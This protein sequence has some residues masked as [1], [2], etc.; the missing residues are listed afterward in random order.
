M[1]I[2]SLHLKLTHQLRN[3][4]RPG[5]ASTALSAVDCALWDLKGKILNLPLMKLWGACRDG[6]EAYGSGGFTN[7]TLFQLE[8]QLSA[9]AG[10]GLKK[11]KMKVGRNPDEDVERVGRARQAVGKEVELFVDANGAYQRKQALAMAERFSDFGVC[12]F[13]EP[14]SSDDLEGLRLLR[15]RGPAGMNIAAGE[16]GY[17]LWYFRHMLEGG[18]V[19]VLQAD[20]SRCQGFT[21]F[22]KIAALCESRGM[23]ISSH[24]APALHAHIDCAVPNLAHAE[25]FYDHVRIEQFFFEG[26]PRLKNGRLMPDPERPGLGIELKRADLKK[27]EV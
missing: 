18:A 25:Y 15:D 2:P 24:T 19:D 17:D 7:E 1:D 12:W 8:E 11:V 5:V 9:W 27:Y 22:F 13:E 26:G 10:E 16:Y 23:R 21:S 20:A 14:V 6:A 3:I 4:G